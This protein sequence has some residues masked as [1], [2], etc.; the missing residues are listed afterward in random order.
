VTPHPGGGQRQEVPHGSLLQPVLFNIFVNDID[1]GIQCIPSK[2]ADNTKLSDAADST[3]GRDAI[4]R[5]LAK[6]GK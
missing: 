6:N 3:E 5:G 1:R 4:E 2:F